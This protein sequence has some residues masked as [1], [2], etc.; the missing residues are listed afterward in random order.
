MAAILSKP[1]CVNEI[2]QSGTAVHMII[3]RKMQFKMV[4]WN[5]ILS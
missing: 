5:I 1:E 4:F 2:Q 3:L